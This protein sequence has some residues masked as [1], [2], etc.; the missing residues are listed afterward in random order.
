MNPENITLSLLVQVKE[1]EG[2]DMAEGSNVTEQ[3]SQLDADEDDMLKAS[4]LALLCGSVQGAR[5][6]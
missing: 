5:S 4:T 6:A 3:L 1:S 2:L